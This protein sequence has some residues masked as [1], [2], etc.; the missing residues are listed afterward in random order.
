M[1]TTKHSPLK[2]FKEIALRNVYFSYDEPGSISKTPTIGPFNFTLKKGEMV[3]IVGGNG[4]G[5]STLLKLLTGL[6]HPTMGEITVDS[7]CVDKSNLAIHRELFSILFLDFHLFDRFYGFKDI[8]EN[9]LQKHLDIMDM[10]STVNYVNGSFT[11]LDLSSGQRKR[12]AII[13]AF[14]DKSPILVLDEA[15]ADLDPAFRQ[16]FYEEYLT[17]QRNAGKTIVAVFS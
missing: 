5:K 12:L 17:E 14:M 2:D 10:S 7:N 3:F 1:C 8:N 15:A 16:F 9:E 11:R 6:Y 13:S 4:S